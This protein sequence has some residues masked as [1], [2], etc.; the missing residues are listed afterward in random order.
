MDEVKGK[1]KGL[2]KKISSGS[3]SS[4]SSSSKFKGQGRV[5][6]S[7]D[8]TVQNSVQ[9]HW[10]SATPLPD[11]QLKTPPKGTGNET[12]EKRIP[13][14]ESH[15]KI[16]EAAG[17]NPKP[18]GFDPFDTCISSRIAPKSGTSLDMFQCPVCSD[19]FKSEQEVSDH[20]ENCLENKQEHA[21]ESARDTTDSR[22]NEL[23]DH[24]GVFL[25]GKPS[26]KTLE[27]VVKLLKNIVSDPSNNKFR[28]IR[29]SNPKIQE[30]VGTA[31]GGVELLE[32]VGFKFQ[33]E[34][35]DL[36]GVMEM[37]SADG[38][39]IFNETIA[40]LEPHMLSPVLSTVSVTSRK[41]DPVEPK[42]I[43]RQVRVFFAASESMAARI[44][45]PDSF[46]QLSAAELKREAES[47]KKKLED[48]QLLIPK[49]FRERQAKACTE[50]I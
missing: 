24:L 6:G 20:V 13:E 39:S 18:E 21:N 45:L 48:S 19:W 8:G 40:L 44:E 37:P 16:T 50:E 49:S 1:V 25:S 29:M 15:L 9:R 31:V 33:A 35:D 22:A 23:V 43:D 41:I 26:D 30:S 2:M 47:R 7:S 27:V 11:K 46:Y 28:R 38:I 12:L 32:Y 3:S 17:S 10:Q 4:S 42:K 34:G 36:W 5:L 14:R